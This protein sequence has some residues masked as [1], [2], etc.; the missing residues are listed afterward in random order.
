[1]YYRISVN[2]GKQ[3]AILLKVIKSVAKT[4]PFVPAAYEA[5]WARRRS[6]MPTQQ[7][8]R[9]VCQKNTWQ[10][11]D[12]VSGP[13]SELGQT[14]TVIAELPELLKELGVAT[15]LDMPCGDFHWMRLV[16][17]HNIRYIGADIVNEVVCHNKRYESDNIT[18]V[19]SDL[20]TD[21]LPKV[22]VVLCRD[23]LVHFSFADIRRAL[24]NI[25]RSA[26]TYLLTTTFPA[27]SK[28]TNIVTG[29]WRVLNLQLEPFNLSAPLRLIVE[30][31]TEEKGRYNDK[32][33]GLWRVDDIRERVK[34]C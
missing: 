12:S 14:K 21:E 32:S 5:Y 3:E 26:S 28:N 27:A 13:G 29:G 30:G 31:C 25:C 18:F 6:R 22:D 4:L 33:L 7:I 23:C 11:I 1:M 24:K 8:F 17:L 16:D 15:L 20:L 19:H 9:D 10:G 2:S 34:N